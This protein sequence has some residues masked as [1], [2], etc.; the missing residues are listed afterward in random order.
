[1]K[2][3]IMAALLAGVMMLQQPVSG[4]CA[5]NTES[6]QKSE[7]TQ[8]SGSSEDTADKSA[9]DSGNTEATGTAAAEE[10]ENSQER[11]KSHLI[12]VLRTMRSKDSGRFWI[13]FTRKVWICPV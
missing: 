11:M 1:M 5:Q 3:K 13:I 8:E 2:K 9:Q 7:S 4:W 10:G 6:T 12:P